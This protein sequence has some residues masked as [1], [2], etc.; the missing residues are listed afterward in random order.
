[1]EEKH[2]QELELY[3]IRLDNAA[4][5]IRMMDEKLKGQR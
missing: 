3:R 4:K 5:T 2:K 1:M